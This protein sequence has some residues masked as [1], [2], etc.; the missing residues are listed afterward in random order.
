VGEIKATMTDP[1]FWIVGIPLAVIL[2]VSMA[3]VGR[4]YRKDQDQ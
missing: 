4:P 1:V 2:F 3:R